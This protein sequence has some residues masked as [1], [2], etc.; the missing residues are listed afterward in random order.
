MPLLGSREKVV[1]LWLAGPIEAK[2]GCDK[3]FV[4]EER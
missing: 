3:E 1:L 2:S 4:K